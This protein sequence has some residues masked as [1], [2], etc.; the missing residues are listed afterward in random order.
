MELKL[1]PPVPDPVAE[2]PNRFVAAGVDVADGVGVVV[3]GFDCPN[4]P[5]PLALV[6][7]EPPPSVKVGFAS[8]VVVVVAAGPPPKLN[9]PP[10]VDVEV[11]RVDWLDFKNPKPVVDALGWRVDVAPREESDGVEV[12][13][14]GFA[15][16]A[17]FPKLNDGAV[18]VVVVV[19]AAGWVVDPKPNE[20]GLAAVAA[21]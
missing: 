21:G 15:A 7:S 13:V 14:G 2:L 11:G 17:V 16:V 1:N 20:N 19:V 8:V 10:V 4:R 9:P 3:T 6:V 12:D 5:V 18:V